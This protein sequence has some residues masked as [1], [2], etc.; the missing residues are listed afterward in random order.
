MKRR[1]F[2]T[3]G[4]AIVALTAAAPAAVAMKMEAVFRGPD[5]IAV[6][7]P[8]PRVTAI[9]LYQ[10]EDDFAKNLIS[11]ALRVDDYPG[12]P[13]NH[14][15]CYW[16]KMARQL[17]EYYDIRDIESLMSCE[18]FSFRM[19]AFGWCFDNPRFFNRVSMEEPTPDQ[20]RDAER[21]IINP[22]T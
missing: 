18:F 7:V 6:S 11:V 1:E 16:L 21:M 12:V 5:L 9:A 19:E 14:Y 10:E 3:R 20:V 13:P 15:Y 2:L 17:I 22:N 4:A 8:R